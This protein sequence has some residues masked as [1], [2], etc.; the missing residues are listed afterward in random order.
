MVIQMGIYTST[1]LYPLLYSEYKNDIPLNSNASLLLSTDDTLLTTTNQNPS[2]AAME[3]QKQI[4]F[5]MAW[6]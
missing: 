5:A 2:R 1:C 6:F 4:D 3:L